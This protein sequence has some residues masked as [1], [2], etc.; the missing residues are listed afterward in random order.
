M[1]SFNTRL[2]TLLGATLI[3]LHCSSLRAAPPLGQDDWKFD[4]IHRVAGRA[5]YRGLITRETPTH[6]YVKRVFRKRGHP[7]VV[8][9][10]RVPRGEVRRILRLKDEERA[11][12]TK[13]LKKLSDERTILT[14]RLRLGKGERVDLPE[15]TKVK[16][17]EVPWGKN[18]NEKAHSYTSTHFRLISNA[19]EDIVQLTAIQLEQV[20]TA[21]VRHLPPQAKVPERVTIVLAGSLE[22]YYRYQAQLLR[23]RKPQIL[24]PAFY[25]PRTR[26]V[27]CGSDLE[28]LSQKIQKV[29]ESHLQLTRQIHEQTKQL[30]VI[31]RNR[32]IPDEVLRPL[33]I[34]I[35]DIKDA[36]SKNE[37][38]FSRTHERFFQRLYHEAF[39]A[40][41]DNAVLEN[42]EQQVPI[43]LNEGLAQIFE[44]AL[45]E[46]GE[47]RVGHADPVRRL[48]IQR[49]VTLKKM[50]PLSRLLQT[51][52][53]QFQVAHASEAQASNNY[54]LMSWGLAFYLTFELQK[55]G[56]PEMDAFV[57]A[58]NEGV[59]PV[60]AFE[61]MVGKSVKEFENDLH[62]YLSHL[63]E[64]GTVAK[65]VR[66]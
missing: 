49:L 57:K 36:Q 44:T 32:P 30:K 7:T 6:V 43:W 29:N 35:E 48:R 3:L 23:M 45:I 11:L 9:L 56:T 63:K 10:D 14:A 24:N 1:I 46:A 52:A 53:R 42:R 18:S 59:N 62:W 40:Y 2:S 28:R 55:L 4:V 51:S 54:Y 17:E 31:Y 25:H 13:R 50:M 34:A 41:L 33:T 47:L 15:E 21:F 66:P 58:I 26:T 27:V 60:S 20:F 37:K 19:R 8:L 5:S 39:H 64:D 61:K 38:L 65:A 22:S 16:L 12:L